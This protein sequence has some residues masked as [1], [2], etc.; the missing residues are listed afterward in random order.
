MQ[1]VELV[2]VA[3]L[4]CCAALALDLNVV[5]LWYTYLSV[6]LGTTLL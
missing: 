4:D 2:A 3:L 5:L 1:A 6:V